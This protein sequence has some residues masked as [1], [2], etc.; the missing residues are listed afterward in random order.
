[1]QP[2]YYGVVIEGGAF[3]HTRS[4]L[5]ARRLLNR[6]GRVRRTPY[7]CVR[8]PG[9][10]KDQEDWNRPVPEDVAKALGK[11]DWALA[12]KLAIQ[13]RWHDD[14]DLTNLVFFARHPEL[15]KEPL[16]RGGPNFKQLSAEWN[17]LNN[18]V[19]KAIGAS[20]E[21][22]DLAVSGHEATDHHRS[23]FRGQAGQRLKKLVED[24]AKAADL[25][26]GL[27]GTIMM[28]ETRRPESYLSSEKVSSYHIGCDDFYEGRAAIQARVPAYSKVRWDKSQMPIEH[29]N[30]AQTNPRM[31]KTIFFDSG[32][33]GA[34]ATAVYVKFRE[35]R[36]RE[37]AKELVKI[38]TVFLCRPGLRSPASPWL[39]DPKA[40]D[41]IS[42][43]RS[44]E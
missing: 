11:Q 13:A 9:T 44:M 8:H 39:P 30:D 12:L 10:K 26:P 32:P 31:V 24:A 18:E 27:L 28:A 16:K 43:M 17:T 25:N 6:N 21:N 41:P 33:D 19:W 20:A 42:R 2:G 38:S 36:L 37:I 22:T 40:P 23:F 7:F 14:N 15:P 5:F 34:L 35:V 29:Q 4:Q 1:M 3:P